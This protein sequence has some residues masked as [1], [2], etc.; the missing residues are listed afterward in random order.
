[1][2]V[3]AV[4]Q[5]SPVASIGILIMLKSRHWQAAIFCNYDLPSL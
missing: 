5:I 4:R 2:E 3:R 1:M